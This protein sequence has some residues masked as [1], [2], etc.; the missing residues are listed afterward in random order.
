VGRQQHFV[1]GLC[2]KQ[3]LWDAREDHGTA[4]NGERSGHKAH[5]IAARTAAV[6]CRCGCVGLTVIIRVGKGCS[7]AESYVQRRKIPF[8]AQQRQTQLPGRRVSLGLLC[9]LREALLA[10]TAESLAGTAV[11]FRT[12]LP[13]WEMEMKGILTPCSK[14]FLHALHGFCS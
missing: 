7:E 5:S 12:V 11:T 4:L 6:G 2:T 13:F 3:W 14:L 10:C 9:A 1:C 8:H